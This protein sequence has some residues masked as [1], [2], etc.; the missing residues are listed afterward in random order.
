MNNI[1]KF[2]KKE[3]RSKSLPRQRVFYLGFRY[4][5]PF[6]CQEVQDLYLKRN[7]LKKGSR[8][9]SLITYGKYDENDYKNYSLELDTCEENDLPDLLDEFDVGN[10]V[11]FDE[12]NEMGWRGQI[13][14]SANVISL[15]HK[16]YNNVIFPKFV[17]P[18]ETGQFNGT[19]IMMESGDAQGR[20]K[21]KSCYAF[22]HYRNRYPLGHVWMNL[23]KLNTNEYA[24]IP[25]KPI[26]KFE[27]HFY[28]KYF[29]DR[30]KT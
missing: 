20:L 7:G 2:P 3:K 8:T 24:A 28:K 4:V 29:I 18:L 21:G 30:K 23:H 5:G 6:L 26:N 27:E 1:L 14:Y 12:L 10:Q 13:D 22:T 17:K 15:I 16:C 11:T 19:D 9:W 25:V